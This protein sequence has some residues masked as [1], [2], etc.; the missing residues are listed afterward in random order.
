MFISGCGCC[1]CKPCPNCSPRCVTL[2]F[3]GFEH[4]TETCNECSFLSGTTFV[5]KRPDGCPTISLS[6]A[7]ATGSGAVLA[8]TVEKQEDGSCTITSL[9]IATECV[10]GGGW[11]SSDEKSGLDG[12]LIP[13]RCRDGDDDKPEDKYADNSNCENVG[14][15]LRGGNYSSPSLVSSLL[16]Y[17]YQ[18]RPATANFT[19]GTV[20]PTGRYS[21][22]GGTG[23]GA[24]V[25]VAGYTEGQWTDSDKSWSINTL[26]AVSGGT[27]YGEGQTVN[28]VPQKST[29]ATLEQAVAKIE[30]VNRA[31][32]WIEVT[33]TTSLGEVYFGGANVQ[34]FT[35]SDGR[36]SYRIASVSPWTPIPRC[37]FTNTQAT[38]ST[39]WNGLPIIFLR[40]PQ[41]NVVLGANQCAVGFEVVD[42][43]SFYITNGIPTK[44]S[45]VSGGA[46]RTTGA[47]TS[48]ELVD[49]G[50]YWPS[51]TCF[52][53]SCPVC[54]VCPETLTP[55]LHP[56][57]TQMYATFQAGIE[58][59]AVTVFERK[60]FTPGSYPP[61]ID[62]PILSATQTSVGD[63][64]EQLDCDDFT[65]EPESVTVGCTTNGT[66]KVSSIACSEKSIGYCDGEGNV[67]E[68]I[69]MSLSGMGNLF[70]WSSGN[71]GMPGMQPCPDPEGGPNVVEYTP[72]CGQCE[73]ASHAISIRGGGTLGGIARY[74][75]SLFL[76][77]FEAVLDRDEHSDC[78]WSWS[79][80]APSPPTETAV[81]GGSTNVNCGGD[82]SVPVSVSIG[83]VGL[84]TT[85]IV[86]AP[87]KAQGETA[88]AE[89]SVS[90]PAAGGAITGVT[91]L[92]PGSGYAR[93]IFTR[94]QPGMTASVEG[95]VGSGATFSVTLTQNGQ[96]EQAT[97]SV[98]SVSVTN[99]GT[100]YTGS[101]LLTF[102]PEQG[103]I[104]VSSAIAYVLLGRTQ[105]TVTASVG[106]GTG[107]V[108][109]VTLAEGVDFFSNQAY[110]YVESVAVTNGGSGHAN[111]AQVVFTVTDGQAEYVAAATIAT[112]VEEPSVSATVSGTGAGATITPTLTQSGNRWGVTS[113]AITTAGSGYSEWD[114]IEFTTSDV[115]ESA[116]YAYVTGVNAT[117]GITALTIYGGGSYY[118][119]SGVIESVQVNSGGSYFKS[120]GIIESVQIFDGGAYYIETPTGTSEVD[121]PTV[122]FLSY[123]ATVAATATAT[124][125]GDVGSPTFGQITGITVTSGGQ[126][127][128]AAGTGWLLSLSVG[129]NHLEKLIGDETPPEP[130]GDDP[131]HC[132]NFWDKNL[133]IGNRVSLEPCPTDLL[134]RS[135][136]MSAGA[137]SLPW[138]DPY[139]EGMN[140]AVWCRQP[141]QFSWYG[142]PTATF[143]EFGNG[144][145]TVALSPGDGEE[146]ENPQ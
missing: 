102:T 65:F 4:G 114:Y 19:I 104:T 52:Y 145:I 115:T 121:V 31:A 109:S 64:G 7:D 45:L 98:S 15:P 20:A 74:S 90:S 67:P 50:E 53:S 73:G 110:W 39:T 133:P 11:V 66:I 21:L 92:T 61:F 68:Q 71:G 86:S 127:Y 42:P 69:T 134:S 32:P 10:G 106:G 118:R 139:G 35:D 44:V 46:Y 130:V 56:N 81:S 88:T 100:G 82:L 38:V 111:G 136:V 75:G 28:L 27:G 97:W 126:R 128:R 119:D 17:G 108:L 85:V 49:G 140:G 23:S 51:N 24:T 34:S 9:E 112:G 12:S 113:A 101:P 3:E 25:S 94:S 123:S 41:I 5:L 14:D 13:W 124:V 129:L 143:F 89:A 107:A 1:G 54:P 117:G 22:S 76:Q 116:G 47:I 36:T 135:Y 16:F 2:T 96:G 79:G 87:T 58:S 55:I 84:E 62:T 99:G 60:W 63:G 37:G 6:V 78:L 40:Q 103:A 125:D 146:E 72:F 80:Y 30:W 33:A 138:G 43:G 141:P 122:S 18:C 144:E 132:N 83:P 105:P 70:L 8:R 57:G 93:E 26:G 120:T 77:D 131:L 137:F 48:V 95:N 91:V 142:A 59:N 29:V